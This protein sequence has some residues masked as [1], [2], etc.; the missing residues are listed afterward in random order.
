MACNPLR[1]IDVLEALQQT[2][3]PKMLNVFGLQ[4]TKIDD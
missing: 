4:S 3:H 2:E 1:A